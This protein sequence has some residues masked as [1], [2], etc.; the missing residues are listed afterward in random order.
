MSGDYSRF[1]FKPGKRFSGVRMQQGRVQLDADWNEEIDILK[2]RWETQALDT[3]GTAAVPKKT[4]PDGFKVSSLS[5]LAVG[6]G[7]MYVDGL[8]AERL[9]GDPQHSNLSLSPQPAAPAA[10]EQAVVYLDVF[11]REVTY[12]EDPEL[13][14]PALGGPDTTTRTQVVWQVKVR[15]VPAASC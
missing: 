5:P 7:R 15:T 11:E 1:T 3:F 8:L 2:R 13:I 14:E 4:T 10:G 9:P 12:V 6:E